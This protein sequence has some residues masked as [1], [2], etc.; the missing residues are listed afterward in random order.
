MSYQIVLTKADAL[1]APALAARRAAT[2][3]AICR[4]PAAYPQVIATSAR[5]GAG[6]AEL[7]ATV[8]RLLHERAR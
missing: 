4:R 2:Q 3:T 1:D 6:I 8:L 5:D 7:R